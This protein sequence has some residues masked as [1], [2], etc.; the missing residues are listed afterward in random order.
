[1]TEQRADFDRLDDLF[2]EQKEF[3]NQIDSKF[4]NQEFSCYNF[5]REEYDIYDDLNCAIQ[6]ATEAIRELNTK[7]WKSKRKIVNKKKV[8]EEIVDCTKFLNQAMIRLGYNS[9]DFY[10]MHKKKSEINR[11]R[12]RTGY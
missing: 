8:L 2:N 4:S 5:T 3:T 12:Q 6:E 11:E 9:N 10:N 7:K 1:L